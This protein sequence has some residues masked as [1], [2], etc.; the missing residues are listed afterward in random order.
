M[1][2]KGHE[3]LAC[4]LRGCRGSMCVILCNRQKGSYRIIIVLMVESIWRV[5]INNYYYIVVWC[6]N[7]FSEIETRFSGVKWANK[8][9]LYPCVVR[10][11][12]Y[13]YN[14]ILR[15]YHFSTI[16]GM[17]TIIIIL[18]IIFLI[19]QVPYINSNSHSQSK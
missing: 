8:S 9:N 11:F 19:P 13:N 6:L 12:K 18:Y 1:F 10:P 5:Y 16:Y 14:M 15:T 4:C 17:R 3:M 7:I 2:I